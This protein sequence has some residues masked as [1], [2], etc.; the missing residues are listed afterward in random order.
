M[1]PGAVQAAGIGRWAGGAYGRGT[2]V[3][4]APAG[5]N[6]SSSQITIS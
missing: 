3:P 5:T 6:I 4:R 2:E 1:G